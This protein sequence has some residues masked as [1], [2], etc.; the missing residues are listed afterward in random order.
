MTSIQTT[1]AQNAASAAAASALPGGDGP[2]RAAFLIACAAAEIP[3]HDDLKDALN[4]I[5]EAMTGD[6]D[7]IENAVD[8]AT[9]SLVDWA[10]Y[11]TGLN[12]GDTTIARRA[13]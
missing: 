9:K 7:D 3:G 10:E 4:I 11:Q 8:M 13:A 2:D 1:R 12:H 5:Y 6:P